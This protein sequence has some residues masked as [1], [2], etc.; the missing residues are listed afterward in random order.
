MNYVHQSEKIIYWADDDEDDRDLIRDVLHELE[1]GC[2]LVHFYNGQ[3]LLEHLENGGDTLQPDLIILDMNMPVLDGRKTLSALK[4][5]ERYKG[6][7]MVIFTTSTSELD[8]KFC[9]W[10]HTQMLSKPYS[11]EALKKVLS[12]ILLLCLDQGV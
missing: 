12:K 7:P 2:R 6:I 5:Q 8:K 4:K 10:M 3:L 9:E 11:Y 1:P